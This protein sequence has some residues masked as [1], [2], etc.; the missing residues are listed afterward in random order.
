MKMFFPPSDVLLLPI[1]NRF[2]VR[3]SFHFIFIGRKKQTSNG[4]VKYV[5]FG[6][7]NAKIQNEYHALCI[8]R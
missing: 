1:E 7:K 3:I 5:L 8:W 2:P 6:G 4:C